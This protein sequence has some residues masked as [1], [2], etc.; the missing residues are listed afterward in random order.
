MFTGGF[1]FS[2]I[3][4][5]KGRYVF[6]FFVMLIPVAAAGLKIALDLFTERIGKMKGEKQKQ[7]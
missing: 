7:A 5:A 6:P 3:W 2:L 4:E 1:L